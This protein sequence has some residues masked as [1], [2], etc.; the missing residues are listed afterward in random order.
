MD[1]VIF[2]CKYFVVHGN[3]TRTE[4]L[5]SHIHRALSGWKAYIRRC[6]ARWQNGIVCDTAITT[7]VPCSLTP[8]LRWSRALFTV[9]ELYLHPRQECLGL[10]FGAEF[11]DEPNLRIMLLFCLQFYR[12]RVRYFINQQ[13]CK[14]PH[15]KPRMLIIR[16]MTTGLAQAV[17]CLTTGWT[18]GRSGFDPRQGWRIYPV[19]P[20]R[21][22]GPPSL[23]S[24]GYRGSFPR[25]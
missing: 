17:E 12:N 20:D 9:L 1:F 18:T 5:N 15:I 24:N 23:L 25:G 10:K 6:A 16:F 2:S 21:L 3:S 7:S 11:W 19:C 4:E 13:F 14:M 22:W 8:W